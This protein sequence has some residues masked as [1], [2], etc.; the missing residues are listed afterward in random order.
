MKLVYKK[1]KQINIRCPTIVKQII[2]RIAE[3]FGPAIDTLS[4]NAIAIKRGTEQESGRDVVDALEMYIP[5]FYPFTT[6]MRK[7]K[8]MFVALPAEVKTTYI[9]QELFK[10]IKRFQLLDQTCFYHQRTYQ[11]VLQECLEAEEGSVVN[12]ALQGPILDHFAA[13][14]S[15]CC[16]FRS[17]R[18]KLK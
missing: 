15:A 1:T 9:A 6:G 7:F 18:I 8:E 5:D 12:D 13:V 11:Q 17:L 14:A 10:M 4:K 16:S 3:E 2:E